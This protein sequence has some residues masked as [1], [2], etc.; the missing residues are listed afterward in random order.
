[1]VGKRIAVYSSGTQRLTGRPA[2]YGLEKWE[3]VCSSWTVRVKVVQVAHGGS[4][5]SIEQAEEYCNWAGDIPKPR[6]TWDWGFD[7]A[8][9]KAHPT[10]KARRCVQRRLQ[11]LAHQW[12]IFIQRSCVSCSF[13]QRSLASCIVPKTALL[14]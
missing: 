7:P 10:P 1:M 9:A 5:R 2:P 14:T 4:S 12:Y 3:L 11:E 6:D 8:V 13:I